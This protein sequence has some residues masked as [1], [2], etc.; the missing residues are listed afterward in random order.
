LPLFLH[1]DYL[2]IIKL[3]FSVQKSFFSIQIIELISYLFL[4]GS[5]ISVGS[6]TLLMF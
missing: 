1:T 4:F 2:E 5:T 6:V 3:I